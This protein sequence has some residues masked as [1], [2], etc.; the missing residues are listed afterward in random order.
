MV[1]SI[2]V[3]WIVHDGGLLMLLPFLLRQHKTWKNT[4][5]R[6]F[7]IAQMED[8]SVRMKHDLER[9]LYHLRIDAQ[10]FVIEMVSA[11][12]R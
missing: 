6:L 1:G 2:D 10:V 11:A 8:N 4:Q 9:F 7:T 5:L 12:S 3:W